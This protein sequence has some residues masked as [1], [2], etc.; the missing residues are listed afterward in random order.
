MLQSLQVRNYVLI[1]SL[2]IDF[3]AGLL[4]ITGQT[5]AGKSILLGAL[6]LVLG[7]K[8]DAS[9]VGE[10]ADNCVVEAEFDMAGDALARRMVEEQGLD[11][12]EGHLTIRRVLGRSGRSRSFLNDEPV[13]LPVLSALSARLL[14]IHSQHQ[15]LLL[16]DHAFQLSMLDHFAGLTG[17]ADTCRT[18]WQ[19]LSGLRKRLADVKEKLAR[20][21]LEKDFNESLF[22]QLETAR[23]RDGELEELEAEQKQLAH[24]EEI[25]E[26]LFAVENML[27]ATEERPSLDALL[28]EAVRQ[29]SRTARFVAPAEALSERLDSARLELEDILG[30]VSDLERAVE[31]SPDRLEAV[32]D[33]M[34][35]LYDLM[36]KHGTDSVAGL[37][38]RRE[39]LSEA[40]FDSTALEGERTRLEAAVAA[41]EQAWEQTAAQLHESR[42]QAAGPFAGA[43]LEKLRFL[44][45]DR[46]LFEVR[47]AEAAPGPSGKDSVLFL[48]S[49]TGRNPVDVARC[50]SGGELSRIMLS[51]KAMM[52]RYTQMP[53]MVFDEID[54]GVSG[55]VA[56]K[57]GSMICEMGRDMQVFAITHLPQVAAKGDAHF[58]VSKE[59]RPDG[60]AVTDIRQITGESR[61]LEIA[62]MLSGAAVTPE[63]VANAESLLK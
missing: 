57:M 56:D 15:T 1:D 62:R 26:G 50:A 38:A 9:M 11:W 47:L 52:A 36:K 5:G 42:A 21:S 13:T 23:L 49:A 37:I 51:L 2:D 58:L 3:P 60:R 27:S 25:K 6:S 40:L 8:A 33:R 4:I 55:S 45:L 43:I 44:E 41:E 48:F 19:E 10:A 17:L 35:L 39:E 7:A 46:S 12:N 20:L 18:H 30:E 22:N 32:E 29:L 16:T 24:A 28:K 63:A 61:V 59:M 53:T 54:T 14:D 31:V 34:S